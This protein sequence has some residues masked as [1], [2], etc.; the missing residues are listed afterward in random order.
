MSNDPNAE[1]TEPFEC[2]DCTADDYSYAFPPNN[3][4]KWM[5]ENMLYSLHTNLEAIRNDNSSTKE[6]NHVALE[7]VAKFTSQRLMHKW[8]RAQPEERVAMGVGV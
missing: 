7:T 2:E 5:R 1:M 6:V 3:L 4:R 8:M